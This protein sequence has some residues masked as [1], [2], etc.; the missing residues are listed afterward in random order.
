MRFASLRKFARDLALSASFVFALAA[1]APGDVAVVGTAAAQAGTTCTLIREYV[2][3]F[4]N[5]WGEYRCGRQI[6]TTG[7]DRSCPYTVWDFREER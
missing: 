3:E 5:R 1:T 6:I 4:G 2:D 7:C